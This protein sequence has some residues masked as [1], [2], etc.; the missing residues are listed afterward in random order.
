MTNQNNIKVTKVDNNP[1]EDINIKK[2]SINQIDK[3]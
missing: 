1:I 2:K 3:E